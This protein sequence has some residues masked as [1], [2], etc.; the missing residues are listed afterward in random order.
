MRTE[1]GPIVIEPDRE[2]LKKTAPIT[3]LVGSKRITQKFISRVRG[4]TIPR[5]M[6]DEKLLRV[7]AARR[8]Q[9]STLLRAVSWQR[10]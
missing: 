4:K 8:L 6:I 9:M 3:F 2:E 5:K 10:K 7:T 1:L